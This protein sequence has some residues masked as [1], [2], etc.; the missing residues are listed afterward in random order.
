MDTT[1]RPLTKKE[2]NELR[3][4][5]A[6]TTSLFRAVAFAAAVVAA[7]AVLRGLHRIVRNAAP[8]LQNDVWWIV[9][10]VLF[11][12]VLYV[13]AGRWT[14]GRSL[15]RLIRADLARGEAALRHVVA[16]DAIEIEEQGCS[17]A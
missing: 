15:R 16:T 11:A 7:G 17:S 2:R 9:P 12:A 10:V 14:G 13:R 5:V 3:G 6:W 8:A 1:F 4:Y